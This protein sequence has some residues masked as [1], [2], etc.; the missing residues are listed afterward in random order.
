VETQEAK[1]ASYDRIGKIKE[2]TNVVQLIKQDDKL[3]LCLAK[4]YESVNALEF[5]SRPHYELYFELM[6]EGTSP[7]IQ[8]TQS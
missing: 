3:P 6:Q 8:N 1:Q 2:E 5:E 4:I 7:F